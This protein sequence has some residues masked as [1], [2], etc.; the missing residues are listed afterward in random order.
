MLFR[1]SEFI[2]FLASGSEKIEQLGATV[3]TLKTSLTT[4]VTDARHASTKSDTASTKCGEIN[5]LV[6]ALT[7]RVKTLEDRNSR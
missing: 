5:A 7:R 2:K 6:T 3:A 1:S 4:A